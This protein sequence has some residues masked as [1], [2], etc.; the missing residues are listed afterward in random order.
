MVAQNYHLSNAFVE[1]N[2]Q[3]TSG[4][5]LRIRNE[6]LRDFRK[7]SVQTWRD[8]EDKIYDIERQIVFTN[9]GIT[10]PSDFSVDFGEKAVIL[11]Q[12]EVEKQNIF[13]LEHNMITPAQ[14]L[15]RRDKDRFD[16]LQEYQDFI[17]ENAEVNNPVVPADESVISLNDV[18]QA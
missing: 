16:T 15:Q 10:L 6:E 9:T 5:S 4:V 12:D 8:I 17:D 11:T 1:G 7:E 14:I 2:E 3:A 18:L 13:D